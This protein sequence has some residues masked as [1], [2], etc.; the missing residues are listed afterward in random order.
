MLG[1]TTQRSERLLMLTLLLGS[2]LTTSPY[3]KDRRYIVGRTTAHMQVHDVNDDLIVF[4]KRMEDFT[5]PADSAIPTADQSE[6][7]FRGLF[8]EFCQAVSHDAFMPMKAG[9]ISLRKPD[10]L[11]RSGNAL[12][13]N[14][15]T[16]FI[17]ISTGHFLTMSVVT[18]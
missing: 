15:P 18:G 13:K 6:Q 8:C 17:N 1:S 16:S 7:Q 9:L 5:F 3:M 11:S 4:D 12:P 10:L 2:T 14:W